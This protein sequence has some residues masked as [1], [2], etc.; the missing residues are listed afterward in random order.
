MESFL[1]PSIIQKVKNEK[2]KCNIA[3]VEGP[4]I[5]LL[6]I[7]SMD[8]QQFYRNFGAVTARVYK[9]RCGHDEI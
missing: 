2:D 1:F 3:P 5:E 7:S 4:Y 6:A 9:S 8:I